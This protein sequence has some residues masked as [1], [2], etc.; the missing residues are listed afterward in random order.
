MPLVRRFKSY[1]NLS[2]TLPKLTRLL[3]EFRFE[4]LARLLPGGGTTSRVGT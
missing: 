1:V 2:T 4:P 3:R